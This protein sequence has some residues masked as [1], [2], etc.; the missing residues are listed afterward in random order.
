MDG[1]NILDWYSCNVMMAV[2]VG[3]TGNSMGINNVDMVS[4]D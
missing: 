4:I 2:T 1:G 3:N